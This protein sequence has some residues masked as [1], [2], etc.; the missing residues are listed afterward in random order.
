MSEI[1]LKKLQ[2]YQLEM[3]RDIVKVCEKN[4]IGYFLTWGSAL[5]A[6]RHGGFIPWDDDIDISMTWDNYKKFEVIAQKELGDKYFYQSQETDEYCFTNWNKVRINNTTCMD[7][8]LSHIKC[9]YGICM[10]IFPLI[11]VPNNKFRSL[12]QKLE[13]LL[14]RFLRYERYLTNRNPEGNTIFKVFYRVIPNKIKKFIEVKLIKN[15]TKYNLHDCE[16]WVEFLSGNYNS[17]IFK[18]EFFGEGTKIKFEDLDVIIPEKFDDYL[19]T[20]YGDYMTLPKEEDRIG[21]GDAIIDFDKSYE[22]YWKN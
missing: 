10:D 15:I 16:L 3:L 2:K 5:G 11:G 22:Y 7:K 1:D 17:M 13:I 9:H 14:Y 8:N 4:K 21:H 12:I 6:I 20:A 18:K 19:K